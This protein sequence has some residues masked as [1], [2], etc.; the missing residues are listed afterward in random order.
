MGALPLRTA[1]QDDADAIDALVQAAYAKWV[2]VLGRKPSPMVEDYHKAVR[3]NLFSLVEEDGELLALIELRPEAD[4]LMIV[5]IAVSEAAQGLGL[6]SALLR[7][8]EDEARRR[9]LP[10]VRLYT[11]ALMAANRALYERRGY[12][13]FHTEIIAD[14]SVIHMRKALA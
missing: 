14:G 8:A 5:N 3:E 2:P 1:T 13:H 10:E 6:G 7:H 12:V 9:S 4:H 11:N